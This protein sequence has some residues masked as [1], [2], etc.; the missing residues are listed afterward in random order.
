[1]STTENRFVSEIEVRAGLDD[2]TVELSF[3]SETPVRRAGGEEVLAHDPASVDL[4]RLNA[5]APVLLEHDREKVVGVVERAWLDVAARKGRAIV[6]FSRNETASDV[7]RDVRDGI[8]KLVSVGYEIVRREA[9]RTGYKATLW[10]PFEISFVAVP[11]DP[12]VGVGR[13]HFSASATT[14]STTSMNSLKHLRERRNALVKRSNEIRTRA[15]NAARALNDDESFLVTSLDAS[16]RE[17]D[18]NIEAEENKRSTRAPNS[19]TFTSDSTDFHSTFDGKPAEY[20][21]VRA[22][23]GIGTGRLDGYEGEVA[24]ELAHQ[25]GRAA[26]GMFVP[27]SAFAKRDMSV[28]G[29][30]GNS[31]GY[32]RPTA[33][34]GFIDALRPR[35][36][37][38]Q[39]GATILGD[40][41]GDVSIPR[42]G[43]ASTAGWKS[44]TAALDEASPE[45]DQLLLRPK[46]IGAFT[47]VSKQLLVQT[48][49]G[50]EDIVRGDLLAAI[51][52]AIDIAGV[53][54]DGTSNK[55]TGILSTSGVG[56]YAMGTN[57][58]A[59]TYAALLAVQKLLADQNAETG[60]LAWLSN[61]SVRAKLAGTTF[62][63]GSGL[64]HLDKAAG[65]GNWAWSNNVPKT[66]VK[67]TSGAVCS[68]VIYGDFSQVMLA[69]F[70]SA[71]DVVVDPFTRATEGITRVVVTTLA[72]VGVRRGEHFA[73]IKDALT[74]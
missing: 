58:G 28:T 71:A 14:Q 64:T 50:V 49:G 5:S 3:S 43:A 41:T 12:A 42:Q 10:R 65:L 30:S 52:Q 15:G 74:A 2:R 73:V 4:A 17:V 61:A 67:G 18:A 21:L 38:A 39:L 48:S 25:A 16:L 55:P 19:S 45:F 47:Q 22:L 29:N 60:N 26:A 8:R 68:A 40:L 6:R 35:L 27:L 69:S 59:I 63:A 51:A 7:L 32:F 33:T 66:L 11:A 1:M 46:R 20:S 34:T 57:G 53:S 72:D 9:S 24:Q 62:D 31:G 37:L 54:G 36:A 23:H 56:T 44:E 70:G 13:S